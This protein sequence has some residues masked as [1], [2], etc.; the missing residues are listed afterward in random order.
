M[1]PHRKINKIVVHCS[2]TKEGKDHTVEDIKHWHKQRGF[3]DIGY[4]YV[5][6]RDGSVHKGRPESIAGAHVQGHN[7]D[8]IG[9]CYIGGLDANGK[10]KD[11]RTEAQ[12]RTLVVLLRSL[13]AKYPN[14]RIVGHRDL[15]PDL[16]GN[17]K[18]DRWEWM[19]E[20]PSFDAE[21][22]YKYL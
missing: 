11:T 10:A 2:A 17:G 14:A 12:R 3:A 9:V 16:N 19:K 18:V 22:E 13:K 1:I 4:H 6:Y 5:I 7:R 8:S 20:C 15:S 21:E